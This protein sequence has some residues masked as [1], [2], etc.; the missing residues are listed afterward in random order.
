MVGVPGRA[1]VVIGRVREVGGV[2]PVYLVITSR[3]MVRRAGVQV[4]GAAP[5]WGL[6]V[7]D[8]LAVAGD[9]GEHIPIA[10]RAVVLP[11]APN[12]YEVELTFRTTTLL[13]LQGQLYLEVW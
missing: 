10:G 4:V 7:D 1:V 5:S 13:H 9:V 11:A 8:H 2:V 3:R 12:V 6:R